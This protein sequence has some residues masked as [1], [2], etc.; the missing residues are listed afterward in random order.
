[1]LFNSW[2]YVFLVVALLPLYYVLRPGRWQVALLILGSFV[3]YAY[4]QPLLLALVVASASINAVTSYLVDRASGDRRREAATDRS[5]RAD[6]PQ[7]S[8]L[9][10]QSSGLREQSPISHLPSSRRRRSS[11]APKASSTTRPT[12]GCSSGFSSTADRV[13]SLSIFSFEHP[14]GTDIR[15]RFAGLD[16]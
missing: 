12:A 13:R 10:S 14:K 7:P 11:P 5:G 4:G 8:G 15:L 3:F 1:M 6:S 16:T 9:Q 2:P